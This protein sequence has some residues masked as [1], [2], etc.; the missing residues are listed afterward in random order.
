MSSTEYNKTST[1]QME[2]KYQALK[3]YNSN[4]I[5]LSDIKALF[6]IVAV[7]A[8]DEY[9]SKTDQRDVIGTKDR[10]DKIARLSRTRSAAVQEKILRFKIKPRL[11]K[12]RDE[13]IAA[14]VTGFQTGI[15][16][17]WK[18]YGILRKRTKRVNPP[19]PGSS[20]G[21]IAR[22]TYRG[23]K[24]FNKDFAEFER[25]LLVLLNSG[26]RKELGKNLKQVRDSVKVTAKR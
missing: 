5:S 11:T 25:S 26:S 3:L 14:F 4:Q 23:F 7:V 12:T 1:Q 16:A 2:R 24:K 17:N 13:E 18:R 21:K 22:P 19:R 9:T 10:L 8:E 15:P 20:K 6:R